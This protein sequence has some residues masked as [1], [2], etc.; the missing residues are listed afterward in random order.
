MRA[1]TRYKTSIQERTGKIVEMIMKDDKER[2]GEEWKDKMGRRV[3]NNKGKREGT[4]GEGMGEVM[5]W[6]KRLTL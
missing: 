4:R 3:L 5:H 2:E 1:S 6:Q